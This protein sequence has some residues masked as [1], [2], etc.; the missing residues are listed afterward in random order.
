MINCFC[1]VLISVLKTALSADDY[2]VAAVV[3]MPST[4]VNVMKG[5]KR[6]PPIQEYIKLINSIDTGLELED[7]SL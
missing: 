2:Y 5:E 3:E 1:F 7:W 4:F 6:G